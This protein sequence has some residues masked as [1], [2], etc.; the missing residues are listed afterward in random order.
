MGC[1][2]TCKLFTSRTFVPVPVQETLMKAITVM[3]TYCQESSCSVTSIRMIVD[4]I[5]SDWLKNQNSFDADH[6]KDLQDMAI[7]ALDYRRAHGQGR[8]MRFDVFAIA[9]K[10]SYVG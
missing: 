9:L 7:V 3:G 2:A 1:D 6:F 4:A 5:Q 8:I 10:R